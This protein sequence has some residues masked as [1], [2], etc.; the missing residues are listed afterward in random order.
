MKK[1]NLTLK[2]YNEFIESAKDGHYPILFND[3][4]DKYKKPEEKI[5]AICYRVR[6]KLEDEERLSLI[7]LWK[8]EKNTRRFCYG[9]KP[10]DNTEEDRARFSGDLE[11]DGDQLEGRKK[12]LSQRIFCAE[13][14]K[15][16]PKRETK[17]YHLLISGSRK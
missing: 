10:C 8:K 5:K 4:A 9:M 7:R 13:E 12:R 11:I 3:L 14:T 2:I 17:K 1:E 6:T 16:L 15:A